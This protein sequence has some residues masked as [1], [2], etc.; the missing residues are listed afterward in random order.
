MHHY[1]ESIKKCSRLTLQFSDA[2]FHD[3][4]DQSDK[5]P[6]DLQTHQSR[7]CNRN[8]MRLGVLVVSL[9]CLNKPLFLIAFCN[10]K[11]QIIVCPIR[12]HTKPL[13]NILPLNFY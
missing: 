10:F 2:Q 4:A 8:V 7:H 5:F 13:I 12:F 9:I 3:L 11:L 6:R 1:Q